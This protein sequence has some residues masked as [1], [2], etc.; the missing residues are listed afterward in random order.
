MWCSAHFLKF[1][2]PIWM[3]TVTSAVITFNTVIKCWAFVF[4]VNAFI[5]NCAA[6]QTQHTQSNTITIRMIHGL[7]YHFFAVHIQRIILIIHC[8]FL[9]E[10]FV[11]QRSVHMNSHCMRL[12]MEKGQLNVIVKCNTMAKYPLCDRCTH[13]T[14]E[15]YLIQTIK[16][17]VHRR[18]DVMCS[19]CKKKHSEIFKRRSHADMMPSAK[20]AVKSQFQE[21]A[22]TQVVYDSLCIFLS[23]SPSLL[24]LLLLRIVLV[25]VD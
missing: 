9:A 23:L 10:C 6:L 18:C 2:Q 13:S 21:A 4:N 15:L 14:L 16:C 3:R 1:G 5:Y 7:Q 17:I 24:L 12:C 20:C 25:E 19:K 11:F 22:H 8:N